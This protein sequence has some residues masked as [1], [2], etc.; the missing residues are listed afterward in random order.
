LAWTSTARGGGRRA[1][2]V[3]VLALTAVRCGSG[4]LFGKEY[5][6]EEDLY[7]SLDGSAELIVNTSIPAL[8][9]LRGLDLDV[10]PRAMV[11]RATIRAAYESPVTEVTR[12]SRPWRRGGR[13]FVQI[14]ISVDDI[15]RL[16]EAKPFAWSTYDLSRAEDAAVFRQTVGASAFKPGT[17]TSVG[18]Q[19]QELVAF[20]LH[21][22]SR[23]LWHNAR[24]IESGETS[25]VERGNILRW[26]QALADRLSG[27][28][29]AIEVR[30]HGQS[31]LYR[32]LWLFAGAFAAAVLAIGLVIWLALRRGAQE[33]AAPVNSTTSN[34]PPANSSNSQFPNSQLPN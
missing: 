29:I 18:W 30:M 28:P 3:L 7:V 31:I 17:L 23:I 21:L 12:V 9:A 20:R 34:T 5:E 14:R 33:E 22:P 2:A 16:P 25:D 26:E 1:A 10:N 27:E 11:D 4:G 8:V 15:R 24:D 6:Y 13:R 32:T 19:G